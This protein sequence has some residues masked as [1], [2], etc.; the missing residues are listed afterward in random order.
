MQ[1]KEEI[2]KVSNKK[3][4]TINKSTI[5][6]ADHMTQILIMHYVEYKNTYDQFLNKYNDPSVKISLI[7]YGKNELGRAQIAKERY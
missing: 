2:Y 3:Q 6:K 4:I 1:H 5:T 7:T